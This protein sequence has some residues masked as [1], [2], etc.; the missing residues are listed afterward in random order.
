M[1]IPVP[2]S[3]PVRLDD[4]IQ[5]IKKVHPEVLDQIRDHVASAA[6]D[7]ADRP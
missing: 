1:T 6:A 3:S 7:V 4:L 5:T 2:R